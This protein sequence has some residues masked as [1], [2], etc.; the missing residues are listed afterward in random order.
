ML[1]AILNHIRVSRWMLDEMAMPGR[2]F[3]EIVE[4]LYGRT[5][6]SERGSESA[7]CL[8]TRNTLTPPSSSW[9]IHEC[10]IVWSVPFFLFSTW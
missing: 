9:W 2:L 6:S 10:S 7:T 3:D 8:L 5:V 1:D 4:L